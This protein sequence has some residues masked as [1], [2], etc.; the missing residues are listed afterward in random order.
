M[1][2]LIKCPELCNAWSSAT[3]RVMPVGKTSVLSVINFTVGCL[4]DIAL[5][6]AQPARINIVLVCSIAV[7]AT[8]SKRMFTNVKSEMLNDCVHFCI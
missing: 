1:I 2:L 7:R 5:I 8:K 3:S 6:F 4:A